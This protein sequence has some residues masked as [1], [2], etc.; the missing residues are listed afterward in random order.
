MLFWQPWSADAEERSAAVLRGALSAS[1]GVL[2]SAMPPRPVLPLDVRAA[3][4]ARLALRRHRRVDVRAPEPRLL[5]AAAWRAGAKQSPVGPCRPKAPSRCS[6]RCSSRA[7][8]TPLLR[9]ARQA[10]DTASSARRRCSPTGPRVWPSR[11][12]RWSCPCARDARAARVARSVA[13]ARSSRVRRR[14]R[15]C[16]ARL[17]AV[18]ER[19]DPRGASDDGGPN[20][21]GWEHGATARW[22]VTT[23][24]ARTDAGAVLQRG[25]PR[26]AHARARAARRGAAH[27]TAASCRTWRLASRGSGPVAAGSTRWRPVR[28]RRWQGWAS[29]S[30]RCAGISCSRC[31]RAAAATGA[32]AWPADVV[33]VHSHSIALTMAGTMRAIPVVL[34][35][36]TTVRDWSA[37]PGWRLSTRRRGGHDRAERCARAPGAARGGAGARLDGMGAPRRGTRGAA[38]R[39]C[40][41]TTP[42]S[43][44]IATGRRCAASARFRGC[45]S[46]AAASSRRGARTCSPRSTAG[47]GRELELDIVTPAPV[48]ERRGVRVHRLGPSDPWLLELQ[49]QADVLCLPTYGDTNP[50]VVLEAMA[51]GTP[52]IS[53]RVGGDP[54]APGRRAA[55]AC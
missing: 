36:D 27:G 17:S 50:W 53:T 49:Q 34:S 22:L 37:M 29:I 43:I 23:L 35:L 14:R 20:S 48:P 16:I 13:G 28:S 55:R 44:S 24:A 39:M 21:L 47:L 46:S 33:H 7:S 18:H 3:A 40:S 25:Q 32:R 6:R 19:L 38:A 9:H 30:A 52:V 42:G 8:G 2:L 12:T 51:C 10:R 54:R 11:P 26:R 45:C 4:G 5:G 41:S 15:S 1:R 31:A